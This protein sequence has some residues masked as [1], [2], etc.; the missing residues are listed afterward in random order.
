[1]MKILQKPPDGRD[2]EPLQPNSS[3]VEIQFDI[4][5]QPYLTF[6]VV[7]ILVIRSL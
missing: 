3:F 2:S 7:I 5:T 6:P 4:T 1:M